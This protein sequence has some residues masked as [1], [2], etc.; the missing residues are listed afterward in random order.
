MWCRKGMKKMGKFRIKHKCKLAK[1]PIHLSQEWAQGVEEKLKADGL[2][3]DKAECSICG[4][5]AIRPQ[6]APCNCH[7]DHELATGLLQ[8][9]ME[10]A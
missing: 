9:Q 8:Q 5:V 10:Q 6:I 3:Y 7:H 1:W 4:E 2:T